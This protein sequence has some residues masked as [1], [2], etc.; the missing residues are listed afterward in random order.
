MVIVVSTINKL[1]GKVANSK[2]SRACF[3]SEI[4]KIMSIF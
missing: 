2:R 1:G 3:A 4:Y